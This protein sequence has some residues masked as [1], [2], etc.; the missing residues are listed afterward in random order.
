MKVRLRLALAALICTASYAQALIPQV[1]FA[2][3]VGKAVD[4]PVTLTGTNPLLG[5]GPGWTAQLNLQE[6][7]GSLTPLLP[8]STF[9]SAGTGA[10][11]IESFL[12]TDI[13]L[14]ILSRLPRNLTTV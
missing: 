3:K 14:E 4:A 1:L 9:R 2:N 6:P 12:V 7:D 13:G 8:S 10:A 5:P 11:Y